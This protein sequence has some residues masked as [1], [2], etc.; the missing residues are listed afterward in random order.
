[1]GVFR[2]GFDEALD[3]GGDQIST[4]S[5]RLRHPRQLHCHGLGTIVPGT[6]CQTDPGS[7]LN[8]AG[9]K[10]RPRE[11]HRDQSM[12][13]AVPGG[14]QGGFAPSDDPECWQPDREFLLIRLVLP[15]SRKGCA[16]I[17]VGIRDLYR[18]LGFALSQS[19][20]S[21]TRAAPGTRIIAAKTQLI[22][23]FPVS[24]WEIRLQSQCRNRPTSGV[25]GKTTKM[26]T[27]GWSQAI[28]GVLRVPCLG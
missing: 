1:M 26:R 6:T 5:Q 14:R 15:G 8:P 22:S 17:V 27:C 24:A 25:N 21:Q 19:I 3:S 11:T 9:R 16:A 2:F 28:P 12:P 7:R 10:V 20:A 23:P 18:S 13:L 4:A